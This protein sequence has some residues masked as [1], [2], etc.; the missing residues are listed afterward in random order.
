MNTEICYYTDSLKFD[1]DAEIV[2][3]QIDES[4]K[5][6]IQLNQT[7][8][9]PTGGGQDYDTGFIGN[10]K[11]LEVI[12]TADGEI[13]H[14]VDREIETNVVKCS[15][16]KERRI[17]NMQHHTGQHI[18]SQSFINTLNIE[19]TSVKIY[20]DK[21]S[22]IDLA[23]ENL[24]SSDLALV[25][26]CANDVIFRNLQIKSYFVSPEKI[27]EIPLRRQ[28][29]KYTENI[30]IVEIETFDFSA[31][32]GTHCTNTGM[33]GL[34]KIIKT[35]KQNKE[36]RIYF[37]AGR[38]ALQYFDTYH[39][40]VS[41]LAKQFNSSPENITTLVKQL[42][43]QNLALQ[44]EMQTAKQKLLPLE[45]QELY[46][47][48]T[49]IGD[50]NLVRLVAKGRSANELRIL[51]TVLQKKDRTVSFIA[52]CDE[53]KFSLIVSCSVDSGKSANEY[54]SKILQ[55]ISGKGGG[56]KDIA[57]GGGEMDY[58]NASKVF[59]ELE[60]MF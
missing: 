8:F 54:L 40:I 56:N 3:K 42:N 7:Y 50:L 48:A 38:Q 46:E 45:A 41:T 22:Y 12:K 55:Q 59:V 47:N 39:S 19:T 51:A 23:T 15:I 57:Q 9:Y 37:V 44:K 32:G 25:E 16:D 58:A 35:E 13:L 36:T 21:P 2:N 11:V 27:G 53:K 5:I 24:K 1:F 60:K 10:A 49:K 17:S 4:G 14:I 34:L 52:N 28:V 29:Q 30:R 43:D 6:M 31:C 33:I 18:L 20:A 26:E